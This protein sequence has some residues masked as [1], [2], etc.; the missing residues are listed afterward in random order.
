MRAAYNHIDDDRVVVTRPA[1]MS[2]LSALLALRLDDPGVF[3]KNVTAS[4]DSQ[5][6]DSHLLRGAVDDMLRRGWR[7]PN[8]WFWEVKRGLWAEN[9]QLVERLLRD[10]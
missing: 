3:F 7:R 6:G 1:A 5:I 10:L 9:D 8:S 4:P 2:E